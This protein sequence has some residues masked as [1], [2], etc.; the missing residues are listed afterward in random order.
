[1]KNISFVVLI[2]M[3][4][5]SCYL[6]KSID[7]PVTVYIDD[8]G[9]RTQLN[10]NSAEARYLNY[11][12]QETYQAEFI[13]ALKNESSY[14]ANVTLVQQLPADYVLKINYFEITESESKETVNDE[15]SPYNGQFYFLTGIDTKAVFDILKD[16][17]KLDSYTAYAQKAEKL[18][19]N[20]DLGQ[21]ISGSNK[22]H[23][24]Y[25]QK[26]LQDDICV[27]LSQKCGKRTWNLF[28][29]KLAKKMK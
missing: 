28:T 20:R 5:Q 6:G 2:F 1:M 26:M 13:K 9:L 25:R 12:T 8:S 4:L 29:Q 22:D 17:N 23:T 7:K 3:L 16:G 15:K 19:N 21:L 18:T 27:D 10:Q 24:E 14:Q 11:T